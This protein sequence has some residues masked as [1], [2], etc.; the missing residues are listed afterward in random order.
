[1]APGGDRRARIVAHLSAA[2]GQPVHAK[3]L[4]QVSTEVTGTTGA[5]VMLMHGAS[6]GGS[7][8]TTN[9]MSDLVEQLQYTLGE[10]PCID[11]YASDRPVLEPDLAHTD[12]PRWSAFTPEA[13]QAGVAAVFGFPV[14]S[15]AVR[16]GAL[17]LCRETTGHLSDDQHLDALVMA[18]LVAQA[19]IMMQAGAAPGQLGLALEEGADFHYVVHAAAGMVAAQL[20]VEVGEALARLRAYAFANDRALTDVAGDVVARTLRFDDDTDGA[21]P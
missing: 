19:V 4:C 20:E 6:P 21:R 12:R 2:D 10:G 11:A 8:C 13:V 15:G 1:M 16:L 7:L 14:R 18:D 9:E 5:G 17:N 3:R